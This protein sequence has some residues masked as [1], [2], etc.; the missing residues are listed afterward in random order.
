[1]K[2]P[3]SLKNS[4]RITIAA[5]IATLLA[6]CA[7][8]LSRPVIAQLA[9]DPPIFMV[10]HPLKF[11]PSNSPYS[12]VVP[13]GFVTDLASIPR[14]LWWWSAPHEE[15]LGPAILHDFLYWQQTCTKDEADALLYVSLRNVGVGANRALAIYTG[16][17]TSAGTRSWEKNSEKRLSGESRFFTIEHAKYLIDSDHIP[18]WTLETYQS[19]A[20]ARGGTLVPPVDIDSI[21]LACKAGMLEYQ[22]IRAI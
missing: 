15:T 13:V 14:F 11:K 4:L 8:S 22:K 10:A 16:V 20:T 7:V 3:M 9:I 19:S 6:S 18:G 1:M 17:R 12:I 5:G 21:K 2:I